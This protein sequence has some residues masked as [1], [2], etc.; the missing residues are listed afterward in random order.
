MTPTDEFGGRK[1]SDEERKALHELAERVDDLKKVV[2]ASR[3]KRLL[4]DVL[5]KVA[6]GVTAIAGAFIAFNQWRAGAGP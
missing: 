1:F 5:I 3:A 6:A 4:W 2:E